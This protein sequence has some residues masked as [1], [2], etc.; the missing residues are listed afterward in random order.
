MALLLLILLPLVGCLLLPLLPE[1]LQPLRVPAAGIALAQMLLALLLWPG[2]PQEFSLAWLPR[3]GLE[4]SLGIDG[5]S[6]P[7]VLLSGLVT[8]MAILASPSDQ[9]RPRLYF[10]L[11]LAT[12]LGL[13]TCLLARN[14]L[15]FLLA[16]EL[17]LIPATLLIA[18]WGGEQRAGA[19]I[20]YLLYNAVSGICILA[21]ILAMAWLN[22]RGFSFDFSDLAAADLPESSAR[23]VLAL[24]L[25]GFGLKLPLVPLHGWQP[26]AYSEAPAPV[27]MLLSGCVSKLGVYGL[28][29][30]GIEFLPDA[31]TAWSPWFAGL[32]AVSAVYG[33]LNAIAQSDMRRLVAYSSIGH[34]GFLLLGLAAATPMSLQGVMAL[35]L[36]HGT[37]T[38]LLFHLVGVIRS[39]TGTTTI[40]DLTGLL[41]P[42][43]GLPFTLGLL[44]VALMASAGIPGLAGF[45]G[46]FLTL[47]GSW[48]VFPVA[49]VICLVASGLTAVY[50]VRL[51]NRVGFG[52]LD[53]ER[54]DYPT[55]N[56]RERLPAMA[57][58][59][60]V[61]IAGIWPQMLLG[62]SETS[63][64]TLALRSQPFTPLIAFAPGQPTI[65]LLS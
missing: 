63:T 60:L 20:R 2:G 25:V 4:F 62:W 65:T 39:K 17:I 28:L 1:R 14:A 35:L 50:A 5:L 61:V 16:L 24:L 46:E 48:T 36:A 37:I 19:A 64:A 52:R 53:N 33:A 12:N 59:A 31:W 56:L 34:M 45:V 32:A 51:F 13:V 38:P 41:N 27:A 7:L 8:A 23:W 18:I 54:T 49:T 11:F 26:I 43:R 10:G 15:L 57:M 44:L 6:L 22:P 30:F 42:Y 55:S 21:G 40:A 58:I 3:L 47:E 29:R 9:S